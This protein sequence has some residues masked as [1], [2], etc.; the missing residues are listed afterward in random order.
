MTKVIGTKLHPKK[1][2]V[3]L[4]KGNW[5]SNSMTQYWKPKYPEMEEGKT[6]YIARIFLSTGS[7]K[8]PT[9]IEEIRW[10]K[11]STYSSWNVGVKNPIQSIDEKF[12][13]S[14]REELKN[15][16]KRSKV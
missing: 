4:R 8:K 5:H 2:K 15:I 16:V 13:K 12:Y 10:Y 1:L 6:N 14:I 7:S 9:T 3:E 11:S